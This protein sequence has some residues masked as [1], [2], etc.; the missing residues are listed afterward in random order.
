MGVNMPA[1]TVVFDAIRKHDG[2]RPRDLYPGEWQTENTLVLPQRECGRLNVHSFT[3]PL[4]LGL[5]FVTFL[6]LAL[7]YCHIPF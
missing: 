4:L 1:R 6:N 2:V 5:S 3:V 7:I